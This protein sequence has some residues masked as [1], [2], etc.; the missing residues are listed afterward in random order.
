MNFYPILDNEVLYSLG[1]GVEILE[2]MPT[3]SVVY[4]CRVRNIIVDRSSGFALSNVTVVDAD[5]FSK[6]TAHAQRDLSSTAA[7][8]I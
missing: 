5:M 2:A 4:A 6:C 8:N 3:K 7:A 1:N